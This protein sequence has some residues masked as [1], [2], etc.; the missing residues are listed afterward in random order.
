[1]KKWPFILQG[2]LLAIVGII[3][4]M[5]PLESIFNLTMV[6]GAFVLASGIMSIIKAFKSYRRGFFIF[7]G[8]IDILFGLTL[9]FSPVYS[10]QFFVIFFGIWGLIRGISALVA[11]FQFKSAGFNFRTIYTICLIILSVLVIL[12][13]VV[14]LAFAPILIGINLI[15]FA[16]FE[17]IL[18]FEI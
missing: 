3:F 10:T 7:N 15:L 1:M 11:E 2:V 18:A 13:P 4:L 14:A 5:Y 12:Y 17:I 6:I 9:L 8:I 16:I